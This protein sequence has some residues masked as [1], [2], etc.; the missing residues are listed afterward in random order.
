M[1]SKKQEEKI[2][3]VIFKGKSL[4][5]FGTRQDIID[6]FE[7]CPSVYLDNYKD[8]DIYEVPRPISFGFVTPSI[9]F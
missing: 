5:A 1:K 3:M 2:Y 4:W 9:V 6:D 8:I 7:E